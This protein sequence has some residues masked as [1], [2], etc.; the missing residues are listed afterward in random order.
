MTS[1]SQDIVAPLSSQDDLELALLLCCAR[2]HRDA[3][4]VAQI[5]QLVHQPIR[6]E[7]LIPLAEW[8]SVLPLVYQTL[9]TVCPEKIPPEISKRLRQSFY[10]ISLNNQLLIQT[11]LILLKQFEDAEIPVLAFKGPLLAI[12]YYGDLNLRQF[13]DLDLLVARNDFER[14]QTLL[15]EKNYQPYQVLG[16]QTA[17]AHSSSGVGID[18]HRALTPP[19]FKFDL[20]FEELRSRLQS[21]S[22]DNQQIDCLSPIDMLLILCVSFCRDRHE[23][24]SR[25]IQLCDIAQLIQAYPNL[26]WHQVLNQSRR[27]G[28]LHMVLVTLALGQQ[29]LQI[30]L[31]KMM[32]TQIQHNSEIESLLHPL[33]TNLLKT[34]LQ[35]QLLQF[36]SETF[37]LD[38]TFYLALRERWS[39]K[40][41]YFLNY[42]AL[43][44]DHPQRIQLPKAFDYLYLIRRT[45]GPKTNL[46]RLKVLLH[47]VK[48]FLRLS[49]QDSIRFIC[50]LALFPCIAIALQHWNIAQIQG[51]LTRLC[52]PL[53]PASP[54]QV[55][56]T[57]RLVEIAARQYSSR[58]ANCLKRSLVLWYLLRCQGI[59]SELRIGVRREQGEFQAH[60]WVECQGKILNDIPD[61][62]QSFAAFDSTLMHK[63][64]SD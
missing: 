40:I 54:V 8:H 46:F 4:T 11:L 20:Q 9:N 27:F 16:W 36:D 3:T 21:C 10:A 24:K 5:H 19:Y 44:V 1:L 7:N 63:L 52:R 58:W 15:R 62:H 48:L 45:I 42:A 50:A 2:T 64:S 29:L 28:I 25:L 57:V 14:A 53:S 51:V 12:S 55:E 26:D 18:L 49:P 60:A 30:P 39:D 33:A 41:P 32:Q 43:P 31:P 13:N 17:F 38:H 35:P 23:Q 37:C 22:F 47:K 56:R 6:W 61:V 59:A 34:N